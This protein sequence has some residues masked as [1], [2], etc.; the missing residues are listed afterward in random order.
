MTLFAFLE[1][2]LA[3]QRQQSS[4]AGV[5]GPLSCG[6][7]APAAGRQPRNTELGGAGRSLGPSTP[8]LFSHLAQA[9]ASLLAPVFGQRGAHPSGRKESC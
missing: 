3:A 6:G 1:N 8:S 5:R 7:R 4:G 2:P 9:L